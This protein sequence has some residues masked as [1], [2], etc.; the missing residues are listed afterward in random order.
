M[1]ELE[2]P[3]MFKSLYDK[4]FLSLTVLLAVLHTM[5]LAAAPVSTRTADNGEPNPVL[6]GNTSDNAMTGLNPGQA[7]P[8][9]TEELIDLVA[10]VA[11]YPDELLAI[12]LPAAAYPLQIVQAARFL[13]Q[14]E[15]DNSLQPDEAWDE[16]V[17]ALLNY[18]EVIELLNKD[19]E[20]TWQLGEAVINQESEVIEAVETFRDRALLAGNLETD[21]HQIVNN[22]DGAI[23]ITPVEKEVIYVPYYEPERV[24]VYQPY[25]VYHY[26]PRPYPV[27]YYPYPVDHYFSSGFFWGITTAFAIGWHSH[28]LNIH[29]WNYYSHPYYGHTYFRNN[30]YYH[31]RSHYGTRHLQARGGRHDG[32]RWRPGRRH[33]AR[34]GH[35]GSN[36]D[37]HGD[38]RV[39][40]TSH[41]S[42]FER[43]NTFRPRPGF[44]GRIRNDA[45][46]GSDGAVVRPGGRTPALARG[47]GRP[48]RGDSA[49]QDIKTPKVVAV[50]QQRKSSGKVKRG[51]LDWDRRSIISKPVAQNKSNGNRTSQTARSQGRINKLRVSSNQNRQRNR[52]DR[53]QAVRTNRPVTVADNRARGRSTNA[54]AQLSSRETRP[55]P[56]P[57]QSQRPVNRSLANRPVPTFNKPSP[58]SRSEGGRSHSNSGHRQGRRNDR[59]RH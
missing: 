50:S 58:S 48:V 24:V 51:R 15:N 17:V 36:N 55:S 45:N 1:A 56:L 32:D 33:G 13:E 54:L 35:R 25:P 31:G 42:G 44:Q 10:P 47:T 22:E 16:S 6:V 3:D 37:L 53:S 28:H 27:Y 29:Q 11:L 23:K 14:L 4:R 26:Y 12:V 52:S 57:R 34:P 49:R 18:P 19:L 43:S 41:G 30:H 5:T 20:W 21:E 39:V 40:A 59:T 2:G 46:N 9:V 7:E 38:N 8:F